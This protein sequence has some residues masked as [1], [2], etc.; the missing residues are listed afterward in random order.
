[1]NCVSFP[2]LPVIQAATPNVNVGLFFFVK[3]NVLSRINK[4]KRDFHQCRIISSLKMCI[5][6]MSVPW[7]NRS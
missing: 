4:N 7:P 2:W 6:I 5:I 1:M 3:N